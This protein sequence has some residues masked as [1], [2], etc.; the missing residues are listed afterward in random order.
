MA[1]SERIELYR[2]IEKLRGKP[3]IVY[4]TSIRP[5]AHGQIAQDA[6]SELLNQLQALPRNV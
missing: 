2:Q 5:N 1:L 6:V 4:V 3:L